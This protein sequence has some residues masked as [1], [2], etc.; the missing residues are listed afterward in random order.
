MAGPMPS[1]VPGNSC[2]TAC[3]ST[4]VQ[5]WRI[6]ARPSAVLAG[7]GRNSASVSG[8]CDRSLRWPSVSLTTTMASGP[9]LGRF[10]SRI[11]TP[12]GVPAGTRNGWCGFAWASVS[13]AMNVRSLLRSGVVVI[14]GRNAKTKTGETTNANDRHNAA[15]FATTYKHHQAVSG[16]YPTSR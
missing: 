4:W 10:S 7:M 13:C 14:P 16:F 11:A 9:V 6:T 3:A 1:F 12:T 2:C 5:E 8:T 15:C